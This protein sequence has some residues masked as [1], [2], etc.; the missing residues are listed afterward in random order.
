M[1]ANNRPEPFNSIVNR[2]YGYMMPKKPKESPKARVRRVD[3]IADRL[4]DKFESPGS[5]DFFCKCAWNLSENDIWTNYEK[6]TKNGVRS[7]LGLFIFLCQLQM[8]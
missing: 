1:S 2:R 6:A 7:P 5:R 4:V 3:N 8:D